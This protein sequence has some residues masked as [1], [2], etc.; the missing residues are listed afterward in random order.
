[1][2]ISFAKQC[3]EGPV[4]PFRLEPAPA[5]SESK[6]HFPL[7][8]TSLI[9]RSLVAKTQKSLAF[10]RLIEKFAYSQPSSFLVKPFGLETRL[11]SLRV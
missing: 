11:H 5:R 9:F 4:K 7:L 8:L 10:T 3:G 6:I 2:C 1:M